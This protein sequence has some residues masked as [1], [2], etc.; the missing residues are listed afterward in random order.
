MNTVTKSILTI[1]AG[2]VVLT[3]IGTLFI[4]KFENLSLLDALYFV[5]VTISTVGYGDIIPTTQEGRIISLVIIVLGVFSVLAIIPVIS[6]YLIQRGISRALGIAGIKRLKNHVLIFK[7]ND[8][9]EQAIQEIKSYDIPFIIIEDDAAVLKKLQELEL[10]FVAGDATE[11]RILRKASADAA[12]G[13]ILTSRKDEENAFVA[14][15]ARE[16]NPSLI[17]AARLEK[18]ENANLLKRAGVE[19]LIDPREAALNILIKS[20]LS[21]YSA[22]FLDR[23]A[24]FRGIS[25]G[26]YRVAGRSPVAGKSIAETGFRSRTGASIVAVWKKDKLITNPPAEMKLEVGDV[27]LL[28]GTKEQL[29]KA[30]RFVERKTR[31]KI[32][33]EDEEKEFP[34]IEVPEVRR[35]FSRVV[36]N[37]ALIV[38]LLVASVVLLPY[39]F[40]IF[41]VLPYSIASF[42]GTLLPLALW[43]AIL[44]LV[45]KMLEDLKVLISI[46]T[47]ILTSAAPGIRRRKDL[48]R[49][50]KDIAYA[51]VVGILFALITPFLSSMPKAKLGLT[52]LGFVISVLFL[53]DAGRI[54]YRYLQEIAGVVAEKIAREVKR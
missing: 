6:S 51:A 32:K 38:M 43:L 10:P 11:E 5:I 23:I 26:Q 35:R 14:M 45:L 7:Y 41:D 48:N 9:A 44:G 2:L 25:L 54:F 28:L 19:Y 31:R 22:E 37:S 18:S 52:Y 46:S 1:I 24:I 39:L 50:V 12:M 21:P 33:V 34:E 13:M 16:L 47:S 40:R 36:F 29:K 17:T 27:L 30:K 8:L 4:M 15:A 3:V 20:V 53:Y 42:M 49:A